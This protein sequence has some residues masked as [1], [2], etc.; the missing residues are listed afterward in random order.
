MSED[1]RKLAGTH[2]SDEGREPAGTRVSANGVRDPRS[3]RG[4]AA[5]LRGAGAPSAPQSPA[6]QGWGPDELRSAGRG[7]TPRSIDLRA[8][9]CPMTWVRTR[10]ALDRLAV[11]DVLEVLLL[12]GEPLENVPRTA[13]EE[14]HRVATREPCPEVGADAWRVVLVKG[15]PAAGSEYLP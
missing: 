10:V 15:E 2:V 14:G 6:Q 4:A 1:G 7:G 5:P 12:A 8:L 3:G 13:E 9:A 11:G